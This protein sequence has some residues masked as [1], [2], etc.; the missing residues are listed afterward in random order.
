VPACWPAGYDCTPPRVLDED[1]VTCVHDCADCTPRFDGFYAY[2]VSGAG[3]P[4]T[5]TIM[6]RRIEVGLSLLNPHVFCIPLVEG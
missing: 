1:A 2:D 6:L 4:A 3:V 5:T